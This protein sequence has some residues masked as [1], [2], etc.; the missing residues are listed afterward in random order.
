MFQLDSRLEADCIFITD[1]KLC[2]VLLMNDANYPWIILVPR[3]ADKKEI[4]DLSPEDQQL[5]TQESSFISHAM[6]KLFN[7]NKLNIAALGNIVSQLHI[8]HIARFTTD[9]AWPNPV[10]GKVSRKEYE[11]TH[12]ENLITRLKN[13]IN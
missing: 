2:R 13:Q 11:I 1:L 6:Q 7:P 8:H 5:L 9:A 4:I 10:W 12:L 3:Q